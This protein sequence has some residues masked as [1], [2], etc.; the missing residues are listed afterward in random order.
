MVYRPSTDSHNGRRPERSGPVPARGTAAGRGRSGAAA[1]P[2]RAAAPAVKHRPP[3]ARAEQ[4]VAAAP[5]RI[6]D[7][8]SAV[9][10]CPAALCWPAG[11][12]IVV[13]G[14]PGS[15]KS[16]LM[17]RAAARTGTLLRIDSQDVRERWTGRLPGW[18]PY[19]VYRPV[20]R[21]AHYRRLWRALRSS[22]SLIVHD[23]GRVSW[24]RRWI[25]R[26]ARR[27][28]GQLH[29][30]L[31]DVPP[32]AALAGQAERGRTVPDRVFARHRRAVARLLAQV[33]AGR[34]PPGC[35]TVTVL[36]GATARTTGGIVFTERA[37]YRS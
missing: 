23:C 26:D 9:P 28:G 3:G 11:H 25:G 10:V 13:S 4:P 37:A 2:S 30:L 29:L 27:R 5:S 36:D 7:L 34:V 6:R 22:A 19:A 24:V 14:L 18:L 35:A 15:G 16:T 21:L 8:R 12:R 20:V 32:D 1:T 17:L 31:L 33:E